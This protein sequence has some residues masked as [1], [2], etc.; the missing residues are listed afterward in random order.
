MHHDHRNAD[1]PVNGSV[2]A[3]VRWVL[4]LVVAAAVCAAT[5]Y[6]MVR[7]ERGQIIEDYALSGADQIGNNAQLRASDFLSQITTGSLII[8][9]IVVAA[10]GLVR[11][12]PL[13]AL[14]GVVV[15]IGGQ[16]V[17]QPL[18][19]ELTRPFLL[20]ATGAPGHNSFPSGHSAIAASIV[21]ALL[22][23]VPFRLR[24]IVGVLGVVAATAISTY[25]VVAK[26]HRL[27]DT[28]GANAVAVG[29]ACLVMIMFTACGAIRLRVVA[30][31][32][33]S[34]ALR[35]AAVVALAAGAMTVS[36]AGVMVIADGWNRT[37]LDWASSDRFLLGSQLLAAATT[38][39]MLL[40]FWA[41]LYRLDLAP[42]QRASVGGRTVVRV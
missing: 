2:R 30:D 19:E 17:A 40:A 15:V 11:G 24:G 1:Y 31:E 41:T 5:Y 27:S 38:V 32:I 35:N 39:L 29:V 42:R 7:T 23:V 34:T 16:I 36:A 6:L 37:P 3:V 18:K 8:T 13:L 28:V 33:G 21:C 25:T 9:T 20:T 14:A 10:I 26:W 12:R 22:V 4:L